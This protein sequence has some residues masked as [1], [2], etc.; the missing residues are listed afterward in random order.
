MASKLRV[1]KVLCVTCG[2]VSAYVGDSVQIG[3]CSRCAR[4]TE[5]KILLAQEVRDA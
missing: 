5:H 4:L 3:F 1:T 2:L